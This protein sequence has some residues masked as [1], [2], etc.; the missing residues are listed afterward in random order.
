MLGSFYGFAAQK[1]A[2]RVVLKSGSPML[3]KF[4][5][6]PE[7]NFTHEGF[8]V[9]C[10][11]EE[12]VVFQFD[13]V[14]YLDFAETVGIAQLSA[15]ELL[16]RVGKASIVIENAGED[17]RLDVWTIDGKSVMSATFHDTYTIERTR[18][19]KGVFIFKINNST[20]KASL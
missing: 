18:L 19:G 4:E 13:E 17:S 6:K 5:S 12:G 7:V 2:L 20:F 14:D 11:N 15:A 1:D 8:D 3:F 10:T 16:F 9:V